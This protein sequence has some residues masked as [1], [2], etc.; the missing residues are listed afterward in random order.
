MSAREAIHALLDRELFTPFHILTTGGES[1]VV[2]NPDL[3]VLMRSQV[4]IA[5]PNFDRASDVPLP[6]VSAVDTLHTGH[7]TDRPDRRRSGGR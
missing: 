7:V 1:F 6:H 3:V 2:R 4:F 5:Q